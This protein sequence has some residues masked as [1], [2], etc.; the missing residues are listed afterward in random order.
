M[1]EYNKQHFDSLFDRGDA[2]TID[3]CRF[4]DCDFSWCGLSLTTSVMLRSTVRNCELINCRSNGSSIGP[5]IL[6]NTRIDGLRTN[7]LLIIWGALFSQVVLSGRIGK[8]KINREVDAIDRSIRTQDP[9]DRARVAF[10]ETV[11]WALDITNARFKQFEMRGIPARLIKRDPESQVI[12]TRESA[13]IEGWRDAISSTNK[14]WPFM[15]D[16]FLNDNED[17]MV[18]VVPLDAPRKAR[19]ELICQLNELRRVGVALPG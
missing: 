9:F 1:N 15:I 12:V 7:D 16:M 18:L 19:D 2:L 6:E 11:D 4:V 10:Y 5:A 14:L 17:D 3:G 8:I 13:S